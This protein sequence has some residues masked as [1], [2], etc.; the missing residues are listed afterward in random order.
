ML[1]AI[2]QKKVDFFSLGKFAFKNLLFN[3]LS[4][5]DIEGAEESIL[6]AIPWNKIDIELGK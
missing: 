2:G 1:L 3:S 6:K 5:L 4:L